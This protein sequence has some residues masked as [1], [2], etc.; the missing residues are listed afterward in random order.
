MSD[1]RKIWEQLDKIL[2]GDRDP[3]ETPLGPTNDCLTA[4]Q[5]VARVKGEK[6]DEQVAKHLEICVSCKKRVEFIKSYT[7]TD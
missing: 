1:N 5:V 7:K 3:F 2:G 6:Q 4:N